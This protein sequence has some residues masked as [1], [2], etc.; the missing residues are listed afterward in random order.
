MASQFVTAVDLLKSL[1]IDMTTEERLRDIARG[2]DRDD[3]SVLAG[4]AAT[5]S[6]TPN[7]TREPMRT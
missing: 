7:T 1:G 6:A 5:I 4:G 3:R 2:L